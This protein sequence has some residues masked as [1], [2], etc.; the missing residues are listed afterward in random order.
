MASAPLSVSPDLLRQRELYYFTLFRCL[1]AALLVLWVLSPLETSGLFIGKGLL[2]AIAI[3]YLISAS[4]FMIIDRLKPDADYLTWAFAVDLL[5]FASLAFLLPG[6]FYSCALLMLV[7]LAAGGLLLDKRY[8]Y[9]LTLGAITVLIA[10]YVLLNIT[11]SFHADIVQVLMFSA[12]YAATVTFCQMLANQAKN[13]QALADSRGQQLAEMAQMSEI[14]IS[15]MRTGVIL[16]DK[17]H[18]VQLTND[19]ARQLSQ[20]S[21][22]KDQPLRRFLPELEKRLWLWRRHPENRPEPLILFEGG[23]EVIPRFVALSMHDMLY[24]AF[25]EDS[26]VFSGRAD[27]LQLATLGRLSASIAHEIRNPLAAI[28]YAQEL[29]SET[30]ELPE[31]DKRLL[32]IIGTQTQ[33]MN[34]IIENVMRLAKREAATPQSIELNA[35]SKQF[36]AE[37]IATHPQDAGHI[38]L[39]PASG[40]AI[41][42]FDPSHLNQVLGILLSNALIYGHEPH[43]PPKIQLSIRLK[44]KSPILEM[45]DSGPGIPPG[46]NHQLFNPFFT[47]SESGTGLGLYIAKQLCEANQAI[48][49]HENAFGG[50]SRFSVKLSSGQNLL[51]QQE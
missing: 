28:S 21:L 8:S 32:E 46:R 38:T 35:F 29:L 16:L 33:R 17:H 11:G 44:D 9:L 20:K 3:V 47:T 18:R 12:T 2:P 30:T 25:L 39:K 45:T 15:R 10:R 19:A 14:I 6:S 5:V 41:G 49:S 13:S 22:D 7:N 50:G 42:L 51:I 36:I 26:R 24:L 34:G 40:P 43:Q 31:A 27:E 37:H 4:T 23:P 48:I 1:E